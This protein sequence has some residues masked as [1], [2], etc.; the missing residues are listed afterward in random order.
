MKEK[1]AYAKL[2]VETGVNIQPGQTLVLSAP[3]ECAPFA[4]LCAAAA[5]E[6]GCREVV[7]VWRDDFMTRQKYLHASDDIFDVVRPWEA[8][9][10]NTLAAEGAAA[11]SIT[12]SDPE[13][14]TGV[15]PD[16]IRR[17]D[18]AYGTAVKKARELQTR[19]AFQWCVASAP[20]YGWARKV[21]P[22]LYE[23]DAVDALWN[24]ILAAARVSGDSDESLAAWKAH[25]DELHARMEILNAYDFRTLHYE[26][27]LGT[28]L[29]LDLP[30]GHF[31][32]GGDETA[33]NGVCFSA[34]I[35][36][37]EV[38]TLPKRDTAEGVVF[39]SLPL[40]LNGH[41]VSDFGFRFHAGK[42][43]EI[44]T[45]SETDRKLL[46]DAVSVDEGASYLGEV[47]LVPYDSPISASGILF[48]NTL[49]DENAACHLAFGAAYPC[50]R[51]A[52]ELPEEKLEALG[53]NTSMT[54]EDFMIGTADLSITGITRDG[55][56]IPVF[57]N[58]NFAF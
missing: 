39:A 23:A 56:R 58:G 15:A 26:N 52:E 45:N 54:H 37:E 48:Y 11:L 44:L 24:A 7:T 29:T 19:N 34:N 21:F 4:R 6:K 46:Q 57:V 30:E 13:L 14:L 8:D 51:G 49:F 25:S 9:R 42:I 41:I 50:I 22:E 35:P 53:L 55:R 18:V 27:A 12:G 32:A 1:R 43:T 20:T 17:A 10:V 31:W 36:T 3:V 28:D 33:A 5:Y 2:L 40:V 47:A 16:R 38:F